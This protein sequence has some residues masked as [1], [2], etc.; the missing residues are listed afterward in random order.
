[1]LEESELATKVKLTHIQRGVRCG[2]C[3]FKWPC[4]PIRLVREN[5]E[6]Q[7]QLV[8]LKARYDKLK[9]GKAS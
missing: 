8:V 6:L 9:Y 5:E 7:S 3:D 4:E 2:Y 1:M